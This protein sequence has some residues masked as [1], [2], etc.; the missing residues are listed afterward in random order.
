MVLT[1]GKAQIRDGLDG[2]EGRGNQES[3][4]SIHPTPV[5]KTT[6]REICIPTFPMGVHFRTL[7]LKFELD[8]I[9]FLLLR[10]LPGGSGR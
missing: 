8:L 1:A 3:G 5:S 6:F 2:T 4:K 7:Q 9:G 10:H